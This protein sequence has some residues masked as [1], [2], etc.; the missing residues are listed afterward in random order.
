MN[1]DKSFWQWVPCVSVGPFQFG[2]PINNYVK[3]YE[4]YEE[5][6]YYRKTGEEKVSPKLCDIC[7]EFENVNEFLTLQYDHSFTIYTK[8][9]LIDDIRIETYLYYKNHDIIFNSIHNV[10]KI[11]DAKHGII[12]TVRK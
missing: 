5:D 10:M 6:E 12:R 2:T 4:L 8:N 3:Q 1:I 11:K 9:F 7:D